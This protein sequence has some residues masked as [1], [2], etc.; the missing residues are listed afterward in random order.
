MC[1]VPFS[2]VTL[3]RGRGCWGVWG[4]EHVGVYS[5]YARRLRVSVK[6]GGFDFENTVVKRK[7]VKIIQRVQKTVE[8]VT[9]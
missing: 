7:S 5:P 2:S 1:R 8:S 3:I 4:R 6:P 9:R